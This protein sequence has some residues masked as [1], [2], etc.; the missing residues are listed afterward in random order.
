MLKDI[1]DIR[2]WFKARD[3]I[4]FERIARRDKV[5]LD[6]AK[7]ET[8]TR[9][10]SEKER[11]LRYYGV[12]LDDLSIYNFVIDTSWL[13]ID[14]VLRILYRVIDGYLERCR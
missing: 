11:F 14:D 10:N 6:H 8:L 4:R 12:D 3:D 2:F 7:R 1:A 9:E 5:D 13:S